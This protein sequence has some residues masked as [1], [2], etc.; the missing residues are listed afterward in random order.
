[1]FKLV[2]LLCIICSLCQ[3]GIKLLQL[4]TLMD[5][6]IKRMYKNFLILIVFTS[7]IL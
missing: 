2:S 3:W 1:M 4:F 5:N 6:Y 7:S